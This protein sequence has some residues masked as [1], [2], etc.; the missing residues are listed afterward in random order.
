MWLRREKV[1]TSM[2]RAADMAFVLFAARLA[3]SR[4]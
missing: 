2:Y 4:R 3:L 1:I